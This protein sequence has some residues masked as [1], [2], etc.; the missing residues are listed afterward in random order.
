M[1]ETVEAF[2]NLGHQLWY[3]GTFYLTEF[4]IV[5]LYIQRPFFLILSVSFVLS[6]V[7]N[8]VRVYLGV[9]LHVNNAP[10]YDQLF[11]L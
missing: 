6:V 2:G 8:V 7:L 3:C 1:N 9:K 10:P 11:T 5:L 4:Y